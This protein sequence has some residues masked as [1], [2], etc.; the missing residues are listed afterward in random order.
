MCHA[1]GILRPA[2]SLTLSGVITMSADASC[3]VFPSGRIQ[4]PER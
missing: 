3:T 4:L 2:I 1:V